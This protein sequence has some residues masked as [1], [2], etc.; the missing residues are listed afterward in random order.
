MARGH[1]PSLASEIQEIFGNLKALYHLRMCV[2]MSCDLN[3]SV[4]RK[5]IK[6]CPP[7][8]ES[9]PTTPLNNCRFL[10]TYIDRFTRWPEVVPLPNITMENVA[11][12]LLNRW[13]SVFGVPSTITTDRRAQFNRPCFIHLQL[14]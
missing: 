3:I 5:N 10:L 11:Q 1:V 8:I 14:C 7:S 2:M 4:H 6:L 12:G 9:L 13:T